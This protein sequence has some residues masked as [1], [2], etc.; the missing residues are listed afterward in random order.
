MT[1]IK[2]YAKTVDCNQRSADFYRYLILWNRAIFPRRIL[3]TESW[4]KKRS[5]FIQVF[6]DKTL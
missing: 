5:A 4:L 3:A 6:C 2:N 1:C